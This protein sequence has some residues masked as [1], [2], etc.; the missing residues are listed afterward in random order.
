[1]A[2]SAVR[3]LACST[4]FETEC[5]PAHFALVDIAH[6][7]IMPPQNAAATIIYQC[8]SASINFPIGVHFTSNAGFVCIALIALLQY[9][10][11]VRNVLLSKQPMEAAYL[12]FSSRLQQLSPY[13]EF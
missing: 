12:Q 1:M 4:I 7:H 11:G 5:A 10:S 8:V 6:I 9:W 2:A 13:A 3:I